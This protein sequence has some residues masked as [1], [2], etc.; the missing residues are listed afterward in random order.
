MALYLPCVPRLPRQAQKQQ[1]E[2]RSP[3]WMRQRAEALEHPFCG[4]VRYAGPLVTDG[5]LHL[6]IVRRDLNRDLA[7]GG[8]EVQRV[9]QQ[10]ADCLG[11]PEAVPLDL[12]YS[13]HLKADGMSDSSS[14]SA[15]PRTAASEL[16]SSWVR[17]YR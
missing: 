15:A 3:V 16:F 2:D 13:L 6:F 5:D 10:I 17:V 8:G 11:Q 4:I 9:V 12:R 14:S 1:K 7:A